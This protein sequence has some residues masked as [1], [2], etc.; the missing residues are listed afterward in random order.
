MKLRKS[1]KQR[2]FKTSVDDRQWFLEF[3][4]TICLWFQEFVMAVYDFND[5]KNLKISS[6][7][8]YW[9]IFYKL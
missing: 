1:T 9:N 4:M 7:C 6:F 3:M 8:V 2:K 5:F